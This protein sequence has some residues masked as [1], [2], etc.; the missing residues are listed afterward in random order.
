MAWLW[1]DHTSYA[2]AEEITQQAK[3]QRTHFLQNVEGLTRQSGSGQNCATL[4]TN[5]TEDITSAYTWVECADWIPAVLKGTSHPSK[6]K[7]RYLCS[8]T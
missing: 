7:T 6:D 4:Q 2:E 1:K 8:R 5:C 3:Q